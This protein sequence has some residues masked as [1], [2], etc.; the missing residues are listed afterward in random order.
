[1]RA[2]KSEMERKSG[3]YGGNQQQDAHEFLGNLINALDEDLLPFS[4]EVSILE[5][6]NDGTANNNDEH[7]S[8]VNKENVVPPSSSSS[9][10][11]IM[12]SSTQADNT[13]KKETSSFS[14]VNPTNKSFHAEVEVQLCCEECGYK[15]CLVMF[16]V[17]TNPPP[18]LSL[19]SYY[20]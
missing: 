12:N 15:R 10:T 4:E 7:T 13:K 17:N 2:F 14:H 11:T 1:M 3:V 19:Q 6:E 8:D 9:S 5:M 18:S 16:T 20:L